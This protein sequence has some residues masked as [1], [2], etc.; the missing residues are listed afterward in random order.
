MSHV[1]HGY[2]YPYPLMN[3]SHHDHHHHHPNVH[4]LYDNH[5]H[6]M[7]MGEKGKR[8]SICIIHIVDPTN[9]QHYYHSLII[10]DGGREE[11]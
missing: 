4:A 11:S 3:A 10:W 7:S 9:H 5:N 8:N 1:D 2:P 6:N